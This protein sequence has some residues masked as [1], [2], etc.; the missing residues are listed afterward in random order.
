MSQTGRP[1]DDNQRAVVAAREP[2]LLVLAGA[3]AGKTHTLIERALGRMADPVNPIVGDRIAMLTFSRRAC[4][5]IAERIDSHLPAG[6]SVPRVMTYH[7]F[8]YEL[9]RQ[10]P[11]V[12]QRSGG[13]PTLMDEADQR[14]TFNVCAREAGLS[15]AELKIARGAYDYLRNHGLDARQPDHAALIRERFVPNDL[16]PEALLTVAEAYEDFKA[17][18][19]V[20]DFS[21]LQVLPCHAL[22]D[23]P[24]FRAAVCEQYDELIVDEAQDTNL[25]QYRLLYL[26]GADSRM[27]VTMVGDD[28]QSIYGWRGAEPEN[29]KR[30]E[31]DF[32]PARYFLGAN[33]RSTPQVVDT[34]ERLVA[35]NPSR[36]PD[37]R[38]YAARAEAVGHAPALH[39]HATSGQACEALAGQIATRIANGERPGDQAVLYRVNRLGTQLESAL[40]RRG[41]PYQI[42]KGLELT[43]R[44]EVQMVFAA[45]RL[46]INEA[47]AA[48]FARLSA[49]VPGFGDTSVERTVE[50]QHAEGGRLIDIARSVGNER[51]RL[52]WNVLEAAVS[53]IGKA[54]PD[55]MAIADDWALCL[56]AYTDWL[57]GLC[58]R[59]DDPQAA[60]E[61]R[62]ANLTYFDRAI[63]GYIGQAR[64]NGEPLSDPLEAWQGVLE[65]SLTGP[66]ETAEAEG[67]DRVTLSTVH[68][69]KGLEWDTVHV[70]GFSETLMPAVPESLDENDPN[71]RDLEEERRLAYV[72]MTRARRTLT[73]HHAEHLDLPGQSRP[74]PLSRFAEEAGLVSDAKPVTRQRTGHRPSAS[75]ANPLFNRPARA[76]KKGPEPGF[77]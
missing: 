49:L 68:K 28:D 32:Q 48:A 25:V 50:I 2:A 14:R 29:L 42:Q 59:A 12:C 34:A 6:E 77:G 38:T 30:F 73:L 72:A 71:G 23:N 57:H 39:Q 15:G 16:G 26:L 75:G 8:G 11:A 18:S 10:E 40:L 60:F 1:L 55:E 21:D 22:R 20:L 7:A 43:K 67:G 46:A 70:L 74:T 4:A 61:E 24:A 52:G 76:K 51:A 64:R 13:R 41:I 54:A 58:R 53:V 66:S 47:D 44:Q 35:H 56:D 5:E 62:V 9:I 37:K 36:D 27:S 69:A 31:R 63:S 33:Y 45:I 19:N 65:L 17:A 3:G